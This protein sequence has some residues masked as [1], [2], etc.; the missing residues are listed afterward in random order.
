M[1]FVRLISRAK[2]QSTTLWCD[3]SPLE[4]L[5]R[6]M[7]QNVHMQPGSWLVSRELT[8][9]AG[10]WDTRLSL[11]DDGEYFSR[12][13]LVSHGTRF[14]PNGMLYYRKKGPGSL[15]SLDGMPGKLESQWLSMRLHIG[16]LRG[17]EDSPRTRSGCV[18]YLQNWLPYF[19]PRRLDLFEEIQ[20][21]AIELGGE[22]KPPPLSWKY[23]LTEKMLG[24]P[25][26][27]KLQ[28]AYN[29]LKHSCLST[30]ER[31]WAGFKRWDI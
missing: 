18:K 31:V 22:V 21:L 27:D 23:A 17:L 25:K 24:V 5:L 8:E 29:G 6:K 16:Y 30:A 14:V 26:A 12:L 11:D 20:K 7:S 19:Y 15:S 28:L 1:K 4:W 10:P 3:L 9:A 13:L 2:P